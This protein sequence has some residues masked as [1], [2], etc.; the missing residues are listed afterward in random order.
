[1][2]QILPQQRTQ[3]VQIRVH[4]PPATDPPK[5]P[6]RRPPPSELPDHR[7]NLARDRHRISQTPEAHPLPPILGHPILCRKCSPHKVTRI[8]PESDQDHLGTYSRSRVSLGEIQC[9]SEG[10]VKRAECVR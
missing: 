4:Q 8:T 10:A 3:P 5:P 6:Q 1:M 7:V 9:D 2:R